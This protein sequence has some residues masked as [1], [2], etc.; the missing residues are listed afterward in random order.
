MTVVGAQKEGKSQAI[1][2]FEGNMNKEI[3]IKW[4]RKFLIKTLVKGNIVILDN[5]GFHK[6]G[7]RL[8]KKAGCDLSYLQ[9]YL[10]DLNP[11]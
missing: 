2:V 6:D 9:P 10:P 1:I 8:L 4:V 3:F 5:A 7:T 11:I